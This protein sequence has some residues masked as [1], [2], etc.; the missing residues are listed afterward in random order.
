[1][2]EAQQ[3]KLGIVNSLITQRPCQS[4]AQA[5]R[6]R[7]SPDENRSG[8][9]RRGVHEQQTVRAFRA[10]WWCTC[11]RRPAAAESFIETDQ[12]SRDLTSALRELFLRR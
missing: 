12:I 5:L 6:L 10:S 3:Q 2:K 11:Q 4:H 1:M 8:G 9:A 7:R